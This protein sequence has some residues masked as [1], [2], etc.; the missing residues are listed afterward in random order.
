MRGSL[1]SAVLDDYERWLGSASL[2]HL[3][4]FLDGAALRAGLV[5]VDLPSRRVFGPLGEQEFSRSLLDRLGRGP[6]SIGWATALELMH[7]ALPDAMRELRSLVRAWEDRPGHA[8]A[9][10]SVVGWQL[11]ERDLQK[12]LQRLAARPGMYLGAKSGWALRC[13]LA[14]MDGGGDWLTLPRLEGLSGVVRAIEDHSELVY[15]SRFGAY[16]VYES[17]PVTL[18]SW[19]GIVAE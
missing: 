7:F 4:N 2:H 1:A 14:G 3:A 9:S 6:L 17:D 10:E 5:G 13:F 11:E 8:P 19:A 15:G 18:L 16:R 12:H